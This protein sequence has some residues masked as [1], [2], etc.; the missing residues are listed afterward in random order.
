MLVIHRRVPS[1]HCCPSLTFLSDIFVCVGML[2]ECILVYHIRGR[3]KVLDSLE[4]K[5][6]MV[7]NHHICAW[8]GTLIL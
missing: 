2:P 6:Q 1:V 7:V 8:N 5:L 4:L 3:K